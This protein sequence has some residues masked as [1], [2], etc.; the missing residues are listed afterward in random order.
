MGHTVYKLLIY[1]SKLHG[2]LPGA[3]SKLPGT[4]EKRN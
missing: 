1:Y 4:L 3:Y 2:A